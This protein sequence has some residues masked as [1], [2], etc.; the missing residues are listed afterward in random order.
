MFEDLDQIP[1]TKLY[2]N[3]RKKKRLA[4]RTGAE[5][6]VKNMTK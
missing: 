6:K 4:Q 5:K 3:E 1:K 2:T